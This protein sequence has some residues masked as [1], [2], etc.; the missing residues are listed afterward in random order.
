MKLKVGLVGL[1]NAWE[2]RH[3]SA[4]RSMSDRFEVRAICE[5]V[6]HRAVQAAREFEADTVD[7]YSALSRRHDIDAVMMLSPQW[8]GMLPIFAACEAG[9]AFYCAGAMDL[10]ADQAEEVKRRV[11]EAG[12]A[13]KVEFAR[14]LTPATL[15]LKELIATQLG[16][17]RLLFCHRRLPHD[18]DSPHSDRA[19]MQE[20]IELVDWC[21]Y[22]VGK[23]PVSVVANGRASSPARGGYRMM[24]VDFAGDGGTA[25]LAQVSCGNYIPSNWLEASSFR[26]PTGMQVTC[27]HGVAFV[28]LPT[29]LVWFNEAGRH[30]ESLEAETP[31]G[32]QLLAQFHRA[33]T[34]LVRSTD[35][36]DSAHLAL[37]TVLAAEQSRQSGCRVDLDR[38][39]R[40]Q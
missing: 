10:T 23:P 2:K 37:Q 35:D 15:R 27:E 40:T 11:M 9:K 21:R 12:I 14:R 29:T 7:G 17:P 24:S 13:F 4:L 34:S 3:R 28:D 22:V 30:V 26:L 33:V 20:L 31:V 8:Y 5:Q 1:G 38:F 6:S 16:E 39:S 25:P 19:V 36:L 18:L 32:E